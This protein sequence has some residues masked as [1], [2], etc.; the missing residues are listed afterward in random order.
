MG[1]R[2]DTTAAT[3]PKVPYEIELKVTAAGFVLSASPQAT[4]EQLAEVLRALRVSN[5]TLSNS[6]QPDIS[7]VDKSSK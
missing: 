2:P 6:L 1:A 5:V 7:D 4:E 3:L